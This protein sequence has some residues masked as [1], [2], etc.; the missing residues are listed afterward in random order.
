MDF[1]INSADELKIIA[2]QANFFQE[3]PEPVQSL[4]PCFP[5]LFFSNSVLRILIGKNH[6]QIKLQ[7]LQVRIWAFGSL[8]HQINS[9]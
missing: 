4:K 1:S 8:V 5:F 9:L 6:R 7:R 2:V 3:S